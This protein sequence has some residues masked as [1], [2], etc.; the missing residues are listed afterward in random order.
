MYSN[1]IPNIQFNFLPEL[2]GV[3]LAMIDKCPYDGNYLFIYFD[4]NKKIQFLN[5]EAKTAWLNLQN[6]LSDYTEIIS[7]S[8]ESYCILDVL[9]L[10]KFAPSLLVL[11]PDVFQQLV[12]TRYGYVVLIVIREI[13]FVKI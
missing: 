1:Q 10:Q 13:V 9:S 7:K 6:D 2:Q 3:A 4:N 5:P 12:T 11:K 8:E